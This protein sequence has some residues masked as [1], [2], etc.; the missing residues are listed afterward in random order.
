MK[1]VIMAGGEGTR[2]RPLTSNQPKPMVPVMNK[3]VMEYIIELLKSHG[4]NEVIATLQFLPALVRNYFGDGS[5]LGV[6]IS[7]SVEDTP[8][9]TAGSVKKVESYLDETFIVI[10]GD[11]LT[12]I[13]LT[14]AVSFH[15]SNKALATL[16][17]KKVENPREFGVVIT[18]ETGRV[19]RFVEKPNWS[20]VF[21]DTVN[22]GIYIL[23]PEVLKYIP[24]DKPFDFS[25]D[26]FPKL[27]KGKK[28]L[29]GFVA[30]GY[31]Q[32]IGNLEQY[33]Q[34]HHDILR[35]LAKIE[36]EGFKLGRSIWVDGGAK[37]DPLASLRGPVIIG[38]NAKVEA[39]A[40]LH[41][42]SV[43]GNNTV[44][45]AGASL[46]RAV[47]G[48]N[49]YIGLGAEL[50]GCIVGRTCDIKNNAR[51]GENVVVGD[52]CTIGKDAVISPGVRIYPFKTVEPGAALS[53]SIIWETRGARV[54]FGRQ[55]VSGLIN[56]DITPRMA[57]RIAVSYGTAIPAGATVAVSSEQI[58]AC[59]IMKEAMIAG[60]TS[61]GVNVWDMDNSPAPVTRY[62]IR[63]EHLAGGVDIRLLPD[64]VQ[65]VEF[66]VFDSNGINISEDMQRNIE[67]YF[68]RGDFRRAFYD[69]MGEVIY[70][71]RTV[72]NYINN[73]VG[74]VDTDVIRRA[75]LK[76][77]VDYGFGRSI[78][79]E[80]DLF[81]RLGVAVIALNGVPG[82]NRP[83]FDRDEIER[84]VR[85]VA[86]SVR[87]LKADMGVL[88][89][90]PGE[91]LTMIDEKGTRIGLSA[92]LIMMLKL[93]AEQR[94]GGTIVLP[95]SITQVADDIAA[96]NGCNV[97]RVRISSAALME[98]SLDDEVVFAGA[99]GGGFIFPEIVPAYAALGS[100]AKLMEILARKKKPIST[101]AA[102]V[103][104]Y[105]I[106]HRQEVCQWER[107][108]SVMRQLMDNVKGKKV[109]YTDGIKVYTKE[110][111]ALLLPD[112]IEPIF[113]VYAEGATERQ[114]DNLAAR[115]AALIRKFRT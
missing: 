113:H 92:S 83:S 70:P 42:Y 77:V 59:E 93:V 63:T 5:N 98:A 19:Q 53:A 68:Y 65:S 105:H 71:P 56:I 60:L 44:V 100:L 62:A 7:Y 41:S 61:T 99:E 27:L 17:L 38:K 34:V 22:T 78:K 111:W 35:G 106:R 13:D 80:P 28:R 58:R 11:A 21:S 57:M 50:R 43:V 23:E 114:T 10:S 24:A 82:D 14:E 84:A 72:E 18:D 89:D 3:P 76:V 102:A 54:L 55:G 75:R 36:P 48:D 81:T 104:R 110:G 67:K 74:K 96:M 12:D 109:E 45:K 29:F 85:Q 103:P 115:Y 1:A 107:K 88:I 2:L 9:G 87:A 16:I 25:K 64:D 20:Q 51:L 37:I 69:E 90:G 91:R 49:C 95:M 46:S 47:V 101:L 73:V 66:D 6:T 39:G 94:K 15:R 4:V 26:L 30:E 79:V 108:G 97:K 40:R 31:W 86:T 112:P 33:L 8:L 52:N 32:D